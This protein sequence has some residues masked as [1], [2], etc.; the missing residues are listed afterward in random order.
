MAIRNSENLTLF[1]VI[2]AR[3]LG[4]VER[5]QGTK[6]MLA[7]SVTIGP[8]ALLLRYVDLSIENALRGVKTWGKM[9]KGSSDVDPIMKV[10]LLFG[11]QLLCKISSK[12]NKNC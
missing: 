5:Q 11:P 9:V 4:S 3:I 10:F 8:R 12:S 1:K 2:Q 7:S 6:I